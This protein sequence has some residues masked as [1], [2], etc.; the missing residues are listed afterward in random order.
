K[1]GEPPVLLLPAGLQLSQIVTPLFYANFLGVPLQDVSLHVG[2]LE[3]A[4]WFAI[5][6]MMSAVL[7]LWCGQRGARPYFASAI[8]SEAR[9][10][11]PRSAFLLCLVLILVAAVFELLGGI[12]D[13]LRQPF[14]ALGGVQWLGVF[15]L[16]CVC[17]VQRRGF[18]YLLL[19]TCLEMI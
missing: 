16:A 2:D 14:L 17:T 19:I 4:T 12:Y 9:L 6:S 8:Q 15:V 18:K 5:G 3:S 1:R 13:G 7:G 10:W 11:T